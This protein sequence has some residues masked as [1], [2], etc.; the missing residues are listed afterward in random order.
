LAAEEQTRQVEAAFVDAQKQSEEAKK[1]LEEAKK[2]PG[3]PHGAIWWLEK[4]LAEAAKFLSQSK[5]GK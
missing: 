3:T 4:D 1:L 5:R 2:K